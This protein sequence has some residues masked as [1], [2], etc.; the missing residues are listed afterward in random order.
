MKILIITLVLFSHFTLS[1]QIRDLDSLKYFI[2][3]QVAVCSKVSDT[4]GS[5]KDRATTFL[6]FGGV[7]PNTKMTA[8]IFKKD[9]QNFKDNPPTYFKGKKVCW[10]GELVMYKERPEIVL[11]SGSRFGWNNSDG[12]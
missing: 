1:S 10:R 2:G 11:K 3:Q 6:H 4:Y 8:V 9:I 12:I 5:K 7:Y